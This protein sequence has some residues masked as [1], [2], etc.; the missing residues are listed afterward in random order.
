MSL[1]PLG[2]TLLIACCALTG[3][4]QQQS[5]Q[6]V[7]KLK[8]FFNAVKPDALLLKNMTPG[9]TT[10]AQILAQMGKP[11]TTRSFTDG[12]KRF[13]YPRGPQGLNTY[14][15]DIDRDGKLQAITQV[16]TADNFAKIRSGMTEDEVR[17]LLGKPGQVAVFPL[18]PE[19]VWSWKWREGGVTEEGIF[20][21]HFD[22]SQRVYTTSRS[23]V[24]RG[25]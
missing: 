22:R 5:D 3:C 12:S 23:D 13:E 25:R 15:V 4:D 6:A 1:K 9:V 11:E 19:T 8:D 24:I 14:M 17:R 16:L 21:V 2:V 20:N 10:E 18:K 7:Q